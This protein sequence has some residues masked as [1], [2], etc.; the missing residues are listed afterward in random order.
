FKRN[1]TG[2]GMFRVVDWRQDAYINLEAVK[3]HWRKDAQGRQMPYLD[4]IEFRFIPEDTVRAASIE[5]GE[6]DV[7]APP[8][9]DVQRLLKSP[10]K[11][12]TAEFNGASL[13]S[14]S[15]NH[16]FPPFDNVNFRRGFVSAMDR[17]TWIKNWQTG[18]EDECRGVLHPANWAFSK[19]VD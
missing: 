4:K 8:T 16:N 19:E 17:Q 15:V 11:L 12:K 3:N 13:T 7:T 5:G 10:G 2:S 14:F 1:P 9:A 6:I 18:R